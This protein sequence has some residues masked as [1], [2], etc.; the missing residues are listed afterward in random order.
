METLC[1]GAAPSIL[2]LYSNPSAYGKWFSSPRGCGMAP[3]VRRHSSELKARWA[4]VVALQPQARSSL[5]RNILPML[6][7][8]ISR[9]V[10]TPQFPRAPMDAGLCPKH[11]NSHMI[12]HRLVWLNQGLAQPCVCTGLGAAPPSPPICGELPL[13]LCSTATLT[14]KAKR[15]HGLGVPQNLQRFQTIPRS[16]GEAGAGVC[17]E[18]FSPTSA[19]LSK[20]SSPAHSSVRA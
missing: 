17:Q 10:L 1:L 9:A 8:S 6:P 7:S 19:A 13:Q 16:V 15:G 2:V 14:R 11:Q 18:G 5:S 4:V 12:L 3:A 20:G